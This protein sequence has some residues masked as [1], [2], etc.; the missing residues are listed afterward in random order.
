[1]GAGPFQALPHGPLH[2]RHLP[3][4]PKGPTQ[5][6]LT[7]L[8][9]EQ[10]V[11]VL[12]CIGQACGMKQLQGLPLLG[13]T[14]VHFWLT[15]WGPTDRILFQITKL[16]RAKQLW[17]PTGGR[18]KSRSKLVKSV[19]SIKHEALQKVWH[20]HR[21]TAGNSSGTGFAYLSS[22]AIT[23]A[24]ASHDSCLCLGMLD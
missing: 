18:P 22:N 16:P 15:F 17:G 20:N 24:Y 5:M 21:H 14:K 11:S 12:L 7:V 9:G 8:F 4:K 3:L 23:K 13:I 1:M 2:R 6:L 19:D 10:G